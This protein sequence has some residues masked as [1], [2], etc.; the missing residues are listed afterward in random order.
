VKGEVEMPYI[1]KFIYHFFL[2]PGIMVVFLSLLGICLYRREKLFAK[3]LF[4][5]ALLLYL[6]LIPITGDIFVHSLEKRYHPP[7]KINGDVLVVLGGGATLDTPDINGKGQL[8]GYAANRLLTAVRL[9]KLTH[10]P[11]IFTGGQVFPDSGNEAEI[12][13]RQLLSL[14]VP[15]NKIF[16][17]NK[18]INTKENGQFTKRILDHNGWHKPVLVTSAFHMERSVRIFKNLNIQVQPYPTDYQTSQKIS[19]YFNQFTPSSGEL[20]LIAAKEYLGILSL[21][22]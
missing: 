21:L 6:F 19:L 22:F 8:S 13:K 4:V 14:G 2:P 1:I 10:L 7:S 20:T 3:F 16:I 15:E 9:Y 11:I 12:A 17:D 5:A 18:S